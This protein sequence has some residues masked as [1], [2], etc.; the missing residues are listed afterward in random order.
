MPPLN[1]EALVQLGISAI[2]P[3]LVA[4]LNDPRPNRAWLRVLVVVLM[5]A[6][7]AALHLW[8]KHTAITW[9]SWGSE[10]LTLLF[11][12]Q[13]VHRLFKVAMGKLED[14]SGNG[15]GV[16]IDGVLKGKATPED[17]SLEADLTRLAELKLKG[18]ITPAEYDAKRAAVLKEKL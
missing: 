6:A 14:V 10:A 9:E 17:D 12:S 7:A 3:P 13:V 1:S 5:V 4:L 11:G 2:I 8:Q 18:Y 15:L 16:L